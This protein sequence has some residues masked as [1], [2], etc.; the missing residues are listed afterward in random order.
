VVARCIKILI[1]RERNKSFLIA[2]KNVMDEKGGWVGC[3]LRLE[4]EL[5][6]DPLGI[7]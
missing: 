7:N 4:G 2:F 1:A 3:S 6:T 5:M